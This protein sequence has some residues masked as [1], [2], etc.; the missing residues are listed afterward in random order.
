MRKTHLTWREAEE[1]MR[2]MEELEEELMILAA[3]RDVLKKRRREQ[4]GFS[5]DPFILLERLINRGL[6]GLE[7]LISKSLLGLERAVI[8]LKRSVVR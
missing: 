1:I 6:L 5:L 3:A 7:Q 2:S 8:R 4:R